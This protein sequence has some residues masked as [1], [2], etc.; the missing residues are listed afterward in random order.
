MNKHR[1]PHSHARLPHDN[2]PQL[3]GSCLKRGTHSM[4]SGGCV[5]PSPGLIPHILNMYGSEG[6]TKRSFQARAGLSPDSFKQ[7]N[8]S[9]KVEPSFPF[10]EFSRTFPILAFDSF[11]PSSFLLEATSGLM[12]CLVRGIL[13][14]RKGKKRF[15]NLHWPGRS[16]RH[17]RQTESIQ[18]LSEGTAAASLGYPTQ[19]LLS[20]AQGKCSG[21][22]KECLVEA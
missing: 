5:C 20:L 14:P 15:H 19:G 12:K 22:S 21:M 1:H 6:P 13:E 7:I 9:L 3:P 2:G 8:F 4:A 11:C 16:L 17:Q 18:R 10:H